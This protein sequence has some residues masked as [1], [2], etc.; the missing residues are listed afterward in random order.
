MGYYT[1]RRAACKHS[2]YFFLRFFTIA[3]WPLFPQ[4]YPQPGDNV[5]DNVD[6]RNHTLAPLNPYKTSQSSAASANEARERSALVRG[7]RRH[8]CEANSIAASQ[9]RYEIAGGAGN[10]SERLPP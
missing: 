8:R 3:R 2:F 9:S 6:G 10:S 1:I 5:V 4:S 7:L